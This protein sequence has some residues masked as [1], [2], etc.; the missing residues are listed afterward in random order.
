[1]LAR[2]TG[3]KAKEPPANGGGLALFERVVQSSARNGFVGGATGSAFGALAGVG[4]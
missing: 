4:R 2:K 3:S 1:M